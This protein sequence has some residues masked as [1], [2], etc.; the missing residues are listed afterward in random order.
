ML[1]SVKGIGPKAAQR[2]IVELKDKI[3][4]DMT[5]EQTSGNALKQ[6]S[7]VN[8]EVV[9]EA[10]SALTMLGFSPAPTQKVVMQIAEEDTTLPV[11][12]I[13]KRALKML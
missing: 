3:S 13:I 12:Q 5:V 11:E 10:V 7:K 9:E 8:L 6:A 1:K 2:I 4:I